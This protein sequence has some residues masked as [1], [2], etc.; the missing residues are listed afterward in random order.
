MTFAGIGAVV[1]GH[2][3]AGGNPLALL[4]VLGVC[5]VVGVLVALPSLRLSGIY[6]ALSTAAFATA[7]D[8]WVFP[9]P[10]FNLFGHNSLRS[11][12]GP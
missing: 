8:A 6:F 3:G 7:M 5:A 10:A 4:A 1:V 11:A 2:L 12:P 9:L